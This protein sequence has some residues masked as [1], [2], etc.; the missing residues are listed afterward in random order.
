MVIT[1]R[2]LNTT[3]VYLSC[4]TMNTLF[5]SAQSTTPK[6]FRHGTDRAITP[7]A[8]L[9]RLSPFLDDFGITRVADVTGMDCI[10]IPTVMVVRP[11]SRSISVSQGKGV[12][13]VTAKV[14]GIMESIEQFH[15]ERVLLPLRLGNLREIAVLGSVA[16]VEQLSAFVRPFDASQRILWISGS[17]LATGSAVWVPFEAIHLDLRLPLPPG[18][19]Y[20]L[21]GSNGLASGNHWLEAISH[22]LCELIERDALSLFLQSDAHY[23]AIRRLNLETVDDPICLELLEK[24]ERASISVS[25]WDITSDLGI[26]CFLCWILEAKDDTFRPVGLAQ[27][28]GCHPTRAIALSRALTEAAQSRVTRIVGSRDDIQ[29]RH[30]KELRAP[31]AVDQYRTQMAR[32][33][34]HGRKFQAV[35]SYVFET[36]DEDVSLLLE[37][38]QAAGVKQVISVDLSPGDYPFHVVRV[39][40]PGLE[41]PA[42]LPGYRRGKRAAEHQARLAKGGDA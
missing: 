19:G 30:L 8:T 4:V 39:L 9:E 36:F 35:P 37:R 27:G 5:S 13:L 21:S 32:T 26:P 24:Y 18:S 3:P 15:A 7:A 25:V 12:S 41:G 22:G 17:D 11:N 40:A 20:F 23:Q 2:D 16:E 28:A 33:A 38:A 1:S 14:S 31:D 10:G 34:G 42:Y 6:L 29:P